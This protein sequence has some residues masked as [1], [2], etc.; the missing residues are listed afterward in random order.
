[1]GGVMTRVPA[2]HRQWI[3]IN[4]VLITAFINIVLNAGLAAAGARGHHIAWWTSNP[5]TTN[6]LYNTLGTLF[7][8]P[9]LTVVGATPAVLKERASGAL[10][11]IEAPF[12]SRLWSWVCVPSVWKRG[13]R[14]GLATLALLGPLDI[15]AV[16][17]LGRHGAEASHFV[18]FQVL[19]AVTLG[20]VVTPL[21]ALAAMSVDSK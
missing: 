7:F 13:A 18:M 21:V 15:L 6:L 8:L 10:A 16:V 11:P 19:F 5:F 17:L 12:T 9:L 20:V 4:S 3:L 14:F 2:T 1:M